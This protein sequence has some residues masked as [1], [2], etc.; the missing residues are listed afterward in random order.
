MKNGKRLMAILMAAAMTLSAAGC[1]SGE[2]GTTAAETAASKTEAAT[3]VSGTTAAGETS[4]KAE[5]GENSS[6][7]FDREKAS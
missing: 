3:A 1:G 5:T 4:S 7:G 2:S 6:G